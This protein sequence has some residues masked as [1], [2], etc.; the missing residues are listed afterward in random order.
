MTELLLDSACLL[1]E[2]SLETMYGSWN[3]YL[4]SY[5]NWEIVVLS[6]GK[7]RENVDVK[8]RIHSTCLAAHYLFSIECD[9]R[10]QLESAFLDIAA[11]G[12]GLIVLLD[13]DG[14]GNGHAA[15]MRAAIFSKAHGSTQS[16]AYHALGYPTDSRSYNGAC[17]VLRKL[18]VS[19][20]RLLTNNPQKAETL[21]SF[22]LKVTTER[23]VVQSASKVD[24]Q[25][26]YRKKALEGHLVEPDSH[27]Q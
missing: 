22:G 27:G 2:R 13:Q 3:E 4:F 7:W 1:A 17:V 10:E 25:E 24:L 16:E 11:E 20:V 5:A 6:F 23:L 18:G 14:R 19:S 8:V 21:R 15:L 12:C 9:C 26:Y